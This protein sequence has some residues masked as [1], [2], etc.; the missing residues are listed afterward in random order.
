LKVSVIIP[1]RNEE[2]NLER[3]LKALIPV[4]ENNQ[5]TRDFELILVDDNSTDA[6]GTIIDHHAQGDS[7][8]IP[9]HR[10]DSPGFGN[11]LK[12]GFSRASGDVLVP[13]MGDLSD[14]PHDIPQLI[15][16]IAEGYDIAYGS[17][18]VPGSIMERYPKAK[19]LANRAFNNL[20][21]LS[22]GMP[23]RDI[24]NA[25]KAYRR[26]VIEAVGPTN[27]ES[28]GFDLTVEIPVKAHVLGFR[29]AEVPVHWSDRTAGEAKLKLSRNGSIY[30]KRFLRLF[31][32]GNLIAL[33]D[34]FR[35]FVKGSWL[36]IALALVFGVL[37]LLAL[38][39]FAGFSTIL[40]LLKGVS[41]PWVFLSC[42]AI[43]VTFV[44]RTWRWS[45]ILRSARHVYPRDML[46]KCIMFSWFLNY[47]VPARLGDVARGVALKTTEDAPSE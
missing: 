35:Y 24:T 6:T 9:V 22:F 40:S 13:V 32:K 19:W 26:E 12:A 25:F 27:L 30:G 39:T 46:F 18:F 34:L 20:V 16:K 8:I 7:R 5:L 28:T 11:A 10:R 15:G 41:W 33:K 42:T 29:S 43:L 38:F 1:A 31:F 47:L 3:L 14:D 44:L 23:Q 17:R 36:G 37:L 45:V 4:L 2:G 21:R